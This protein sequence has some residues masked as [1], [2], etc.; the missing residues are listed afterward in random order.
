[1]PSLASL[2]AHALNAVLHRKIK[3]HFGRAQDA[4]RFRKIFARLFDQRLLQPRSGIDYADCRVGGIPCERVRM[5]DGPRLFYLHGGGFCAMSSRSYRSLTG[6]LARR[7]FDVLVPSYRLAPE[8]PFPAA[9]DDAVAAWRAFAAEGPC[10]I[11]GDSAGGNLA[12][13]LMIRARDEGLPMPSAA[14][15][16]SPITDLLGTGPSHAANSQRDAMFDADVFRR[17]AAAYLAGS[18]ATHP[19]ASP[20]YDTLCGLPPLLVH[21][22]ET[23]VLRDDAVGLAAKVRAS[24]GRA[25]LKVWNV[26][27][28]GWQFADPMLPEA[29][30]SLDEAARF[31]REHR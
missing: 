12:L 14:V 29:R 8:F 13:A 21:V 16:F 19:H 7:G 30:R 27:P 10:A 20:L 5:G 2:R 17:L 31:L 23:E 11:G 26:V 6:S 9:L 1:M 25:D 28:H 3:H 24:G 15:L 22:G 4:R 18:A